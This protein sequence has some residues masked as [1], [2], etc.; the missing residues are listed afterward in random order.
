[1][2]RWQNDVYVHKESYENLLKAL[3]VFNILNEGF[4]ETS[5]KIRHKTVSDILR[6]YE[7]LVLEAGQVSYNI[8][9]IFADLRLNG[10]L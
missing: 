4:E 3:A 10:K 9:R 7:V 5:G 1:M 2:H 8:N 6:R